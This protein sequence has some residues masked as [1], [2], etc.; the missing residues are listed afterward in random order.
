MHNV[1]IGRTI[2]LSFINDGQSKVTDGEGSLDLTIDFIFG[3]IASFQSERDVHGTVNDG[4]STFPFRREGMFLCN[5]SSLDDGCSDGK[6]SIVGRKSTFSS[7]SVILTL[8]FCCC[9]WSSRYLAVDSPA[10][11]PPRMRMRSHFSL[12]VV[13]LC[14]TFPRVGDAS[15]LSGRCF[16]IGIAFA[17]VEA[18][19]M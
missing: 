1:T 14:S 7:M 17:S 11:P 18:A 3:S 2:S 15:V 9:A 12:V 19:V 6:V 5:L 8:V 13:T 10:I 4:Q 16:W